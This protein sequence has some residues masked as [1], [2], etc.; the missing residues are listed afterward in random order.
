MTGIYFYSIYVHQNY[1]QIIN[2]EDIIPYCNHNI[3]PA[4]QTLTFCPNLRI[5]SVCNK[6]KLIP[7]SVMHYF[8]VIM[9]INYLVEN[10]TLHISDD[11]DLSFSSIMDISKIPSVFRSLT[12]CISIINK[13]LLLWQ[14]VSYSLLFTSNIYIYQ[15][16]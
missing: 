3:L 12:F 13:Y 14:S 2:G 11:P 10:N 4:N 5:Y 9:E 15:Y 16:I 1:S 8:S 6:N 7:F